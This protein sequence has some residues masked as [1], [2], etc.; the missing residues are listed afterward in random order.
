MTASEKVNYFLGKSFDSNNEFINLPNINFNKNSKIFTILNNNTE[1]IKVP[2][3][4]IKNYLNLDKIN[5]LNSSINFILN[6]NNVL[7]HYKTLESVFYGMNYNV[8]SLNTYLTKDCIIKVGKGLILNNNDEILFMVESI[9]N[10]NTI[11][12]DCYIVYINK[13]VF[14]NKNYINDF[15][16]NKIYKRLIFDDNSFLQD[17]TKDVIITNNI[18]CFINLDINE[19]FE[20]LNNNCNNILNQDKE[21]LIKSLKKD[22]TY[23]SSNDEFLPF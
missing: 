14:N 1:Y 17:I 16:A 13:I 12:T 18:P 2:T 3:F 8:S 6:E 10:K 4:F 22:L 11:T 5:S 9:I 21:L 15:I 7:N 20:T 19:N 23:D